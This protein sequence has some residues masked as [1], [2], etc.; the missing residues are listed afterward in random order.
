MAK[1]L[2]SVDAIKLVADTMEQ[3]EYRNQ[4]LSRQQS[5]LDGLRNDILHYIELEKMPTGMYTRLVFQLKDVL[6]KRRAIKDE[7]L[8]I[9]NFKGT[10]N[11]AIKKYPSWLEETLEKVNNQ[12]YTP[13]TKTLEELITK[14]GE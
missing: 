2:N 7:L 9:N 1:T 10:F 14:T 4:F 5:E 3:L 13:R 12:T 6:K 8:L 11:M